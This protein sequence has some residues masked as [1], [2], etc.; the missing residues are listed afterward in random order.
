[1]ERFLFIATALSFLCLTF[2]AD[3]SSQGILIW[4]NGR[5]ACYE[6]YRCCS[7]T[8]CCP[9][10]TACCRGGKACCRRLGSLEIPVQKA[11]AVAHRN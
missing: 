9:L 4:C 11:T 1:M 2:V 10:S 6:G 8:G 3:T 5:T 7:E